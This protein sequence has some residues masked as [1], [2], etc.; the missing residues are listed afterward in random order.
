MYERTYI[1]I[2]TRILKTIKWPQWKINNKTIIVGLIK[3]KK[4]A[5]TKNFPE[6]TF[7]TKKTI[8]IDV[9]KTCKT[10]VMNDA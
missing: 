5:L 9:N 3:W 6:L 4:T 1:G 10:N 8:I 2:I 7:S